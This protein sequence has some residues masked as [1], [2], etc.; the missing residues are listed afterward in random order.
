MNISTY[1]KVEAEPGRQGSRVCLPRAKSAFLWVPCLGCLLPQQ[2]YLL[3]FLVEVPK[4]R[5]AWEEACFSTR[6]GTNLRLTRWPSWACRADCPNSLKIRKGRNP[7][8]SKPASSAL[9]QLISH[10]WLIIECSSNKTN[11][12][13]A[14]QRKQYFAQ[15][16]GSSHRRTS[17]TSLLK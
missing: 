10:R 7:F 13:R 1:E 15:K 5:S 12:N 8:F 14:A 9:R 4:W 2:S 17:I 6:A 16:N 11:S 3:L